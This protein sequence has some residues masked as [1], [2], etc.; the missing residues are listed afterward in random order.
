MPKDRAQKEKIRKELEEIKGLKVLNNM[1]KKSDIESVFLM[2]PSRDSETIKESIADRIISDLERYD[3]KDERELKRIDDLVMEKAEP[4]RT[5]KPKASR[6]KKKARRRIL[7]LFRK[8][9][10]GKGKK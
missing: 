3:K 2:T 8:K 4:K 6:A 5:Q 9:R 1:V 10:K 7:R